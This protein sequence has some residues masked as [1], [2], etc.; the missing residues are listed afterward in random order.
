[1]RKD[2]AEYIEG[3]YDVDDLRVNGHPIWTYLRMVY[4]A[5]FQRRM[6][7]YPQTKSGRVRSVSQTMAQLRS[8]F[9]GAHHAFKRRPYIVFSDAALR[10][11]VNGL[12]VDKQFDYLIEKI[13]QDK[14]LCVESLTAV[15]PT[16][17]PRQLVPT[18]NHMSYSFFLLGSLPFWLQ[19]VRLS[20]ESLLETLKNKFDITL[21]H[22]Y[23]FRN[24]MAQHALMKLWL[25]WFR[26]NIIFINSYYG[27]MP[28][29]KAAKDLG[30]PVVEI[31]HGM[32]EHDDIAFFARKPNLDLSY[33]PDYFLCFGEREKT[34]F[35]TNP[36]PLIPKENV[37]PVGSYLIDLAKRTFK[38]NAD[39]ETKKAQF[40]VTI[41]V[42]GQDEREE[43][44]LDFMKKVTQLNSDILF[45]YVPRRLDTN[46]IPKVFNVPQAIVIID[47]ISVY[48]AIL[49]AD[50]HSAVH[51]TCAIEAL[52]LGVQNILMDLDG[53]SSTFFG[54]VLTDKD[55]TQFAKTPEDFVSCLNNAKHFSSEDIIQRNRNNISDGFCQKIDSFLVMLHC[56]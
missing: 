54:T 30:I 36:Y 37:F 38:P 11:K 56:I 43:D 26:P 28:I 53:I 44:I 24:F 8:C 45:L 48:D 55:V 46:G 50:F 13:G 12:Y 34:Y 15:Q 18:V 31:Q 19:R 52:S 16:H 49:H 51:S 21:N 22:P 33:F 6:M 20:G 40:K 32:I 23:F 29:I 1:M 14:V 39:I 5:Y 9:Y 27:K 3:H 42:S 35:Y 17:Y 10:K 41:T 7:G 4:H 25:K 47:M 2:E